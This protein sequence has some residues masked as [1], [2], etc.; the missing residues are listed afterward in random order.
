MDDSTIKL[1]ARL[2]Q[3]KSAK[4][5][6]ADIDRLQGKIDKLEVK[7]EIDPKVIDNSKSL[8]KYLAD[9]A[10]E[11]TP[12]RSGILTFA[13]VIDNAHQAVSAVKELNS[14]LTDLNGTTL[15][16]NYQQ[17]Q[18]PNVLSRE[19]NNLAIAKDTENARNLSDRKNTSSIL[20]AINSIGNGLDWL[21]DKLKTF[22]S[23]NTLINTFV[24]N[25][26]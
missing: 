1:Q 21:A 23:I 14:A 7:A 2:D 25:F 15:T 13:K 18:L 11:L 26:A 10:K 3:T 12:W 5:I 22:G 16:A 17:I 24:K 4:N 19:Q 9:R 8:L 6:N 20:H